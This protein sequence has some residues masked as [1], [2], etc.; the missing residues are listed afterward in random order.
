[1]NVARGSMQRGQAINVWRGVMARCRQ[2]LVPGVGD[3]QRGIKVSPAAF[4]LPTWLMLE[5]CKSSAKSLALP[6]AL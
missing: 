3:L 2:A 4:G 6:Q 1:M 5:S